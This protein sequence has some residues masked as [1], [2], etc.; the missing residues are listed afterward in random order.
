MGR[1]GCASAMGM[2]KFPSS[3]SSPKALCNQFIDYYIC[4]RG[5]SDYDFQYTRLLNVFLQIYRQV[6]NIRRTLEGNEIVDHSDV[7][8]ASPVGAASTTS[9][10]STQHLDSMGWAEATACWDENHLSFEI[11]DHSDVV[12]ASPV[13]AASTTSSFS[14]QHLDSMGWAEATACWDENHLS[15]D[16]G[17]VLY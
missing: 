12:G 14:T 4:S 15:F 3:C 10:F 8:G 5:V 7:V 17:C 2:I 6:S 16:F 11:V 9:S 1:R 13:G